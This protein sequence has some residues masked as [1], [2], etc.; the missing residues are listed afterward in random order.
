MIQKPTPRPTLYVVNRTMFGYEV[1]NY[2]APATPYKFLNI[3]T[4]ACEQLN[5][6][7]LTDE[8]SA[9]VLKHGARLHFLFK[10]QPLRDAMQAKTNLQDMVLHR[11]RQHTAAHV[12]HLLNE[13]AI[14]SIRFLAHER[15]PYST[16]YGKLYCLLTAF[17]AMYAPPITEQAPP[18]DYINSPAMRDFY[19][20]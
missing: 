13:N 14:H 7:M 5:I 11:T 8:C 12:W 6:D 1:T 3:A 16:D 2:K 18:P 10:G 17:Y 9:F 4:A 20:R 15:E 19:A